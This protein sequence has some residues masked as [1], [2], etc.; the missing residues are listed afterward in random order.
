MQGR[1]MMRYDT[2]RRFIRESE[3]TGNDRLVLVAVAFHADVEGWAE[4]ARR[5][6]A[7]FAAVH[8]NTVTRALQ[9][10]EKLGDL[11]VVHR[12]GVPSYYRLDPTRIVGATTLTTQGGAP[13][14]TNPQIDPHHSD[15][16]RPSPRRVS[17][18]P[19]RRLKDR[20]KEEGRAIRSA[21]PY[22]LRGCA[23]GRPAA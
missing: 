9:R 4:P 5:V 18:Q 10:L 22:G 21:K 3:S 6:L 1:R 7:E 8:P 14:L 2:I 15:G 23:K 13:T 11:T 12:S 16:E 19:Q 20:L 17:D